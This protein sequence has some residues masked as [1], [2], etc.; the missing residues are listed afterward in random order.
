MQYAA[1][2]GSV[3]AGRLACVEH[4]HRDRRLK[5]LTVL[6]DKKITAV[7][8]ACRCAQA[9]AAA[10]LERLAGLEQ[11]LVAYHAQALDLLAVAARVADDPV[12]RNQLRRDLTGIGDG[13][14]V[15][16]AVHLL[17]RR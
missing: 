3:G 7:H 5:A 12:A 10:V 17:L 14:G 16:K 15:G 6:G 11:R 1:A 2:T 13:D 9:R 4:K 8:G